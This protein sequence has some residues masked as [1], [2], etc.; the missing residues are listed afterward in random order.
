MDQDVDNRFRA[1]EQRLAE[2][3]QAHTHEGDAMRGMFELV[4]RIDGNMTSLV[5]RV[6][7]LEM[8]GDRIES[9][10]DRVEWCLDRVETR[11]GALEMN[12]SLLNARSAV[13]DGKLDAILALMRQP[14]GTATH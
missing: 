7:G 2:V 8:R 10:I 13:M 4:Q 1:I 11:L 12:F 9:R 14:P 5:G 6:A 3:E